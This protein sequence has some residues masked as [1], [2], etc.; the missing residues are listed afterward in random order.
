MEARKDKGSD[1]EEKIFE[2]FTR[3]LISSHEYILTQIYN[4][5]KQTANKYMQVKAI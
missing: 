1:E 2:E 5:I 3:T 4:H